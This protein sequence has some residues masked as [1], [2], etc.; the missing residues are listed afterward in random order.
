MRSPLGEKPI[1]VLLIGFCFVALIVLVTNYVKY[2]R[3]QDLMVLGTISTA[4]TE[5]LTATKEIKLMN[6]PSE[7]AVHVGL[8]SGALYSVFH[9][10]ND[11]GVKHL[12]GISLVLRGDALII[13]A[14]QTHSPKDVAQAETFV[15]VVSNQL[16]TCFTVNG[17]IISKQKLNAA[18][19]AIYQAMDEE[20]RQAYANS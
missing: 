10:M 15:G 16:S 7:I 19:A 3:M 8:A 14:P 17:E 11:V 1:R 13:G 20:N 5:T 4:Y 18:I 9:A 6:E 12:M 2:R